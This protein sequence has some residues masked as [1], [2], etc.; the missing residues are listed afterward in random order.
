M[1]V[2]GTKFVF[3]KL[4]T[5]NVYRIAYFCIFIHITLLSMHDASFYGVERDT[6]RQYYTLYFSDVELCKS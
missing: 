1:L 5:M 2:L 6:E 4:V 3:A